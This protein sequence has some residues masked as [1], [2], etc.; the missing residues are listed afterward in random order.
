VFL[1]SPEPQLSWL[2]I[3]LVLSLSRSS[4]AAAIGCLF[5]SSLLYPFVKLPVIFVA[6]ASMLSKRIG[7]FAAAAVTYACVG[8]GTYLFA[9]YWVEPSLTQF[10]VFSRLPVFSLTGS[11]GAIL[12]M[13]NRAYIPAPLIGL[14]VSLVLSIWATEN[15]QTLSG[16]LVTP[17]NYEQYWGVVALAVISSVVLVKR[18]KIM[19][20]WFFRSLCYLRRT[21]PYSSSAIWRSTRV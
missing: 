6:L 1:R 3:A 16:W 7:I 14:C 2:I 11:I 18:T 9:K 15:V 8:V 12:L 17:V 4:R 19:V 21:A 5:A 10:F 20:V 13:L